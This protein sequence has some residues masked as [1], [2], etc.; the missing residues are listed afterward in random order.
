M[1]ERELAVIGRFYFAASGHA[2]PRAISS[3]ARAFNESCLKGTPRDV[4][5][6]RGVGA[7][8]NFVSVRE[9][10]VAELPTERREK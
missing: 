9:T 6:A 4:K 5:F 1:R 10:V 7:I 3:A 2:P 8:V